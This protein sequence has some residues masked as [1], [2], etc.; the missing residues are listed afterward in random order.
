MTDRY[1]VIGNPI[2]HSKSPRIHAA[3]AAQ[4]G[5]A[6]EYGRILGDPGGF[7]GQV[8]GFFSRGGRGLNVTVP[9]KE[10]AWHLADEHAPRA[11]LAGAANTLILLPNG[12]IRGDN[13]D[14]VGLVR[15]LTGNQGLV[16]AGLRVLLLGAGGAARGVVGPLL[17]A[18]PAALVIANRTPAKAIA[19]AARLAGQ[20]P[21]RGCG[22]ESLS[23]TGFDLI[24]NATAA[25]LGGEVPAIPDDCLA[26][27]GVTY[28][29]M[30]ADRPTAFVEWGRA[31]GPSMASACCWSRQRN[32]SFCGAACAR[33]PDR[34]GPC[35]GR[36]RRARISNCPAARR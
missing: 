22:L 33:T 29:L 24:I 19:L 28:D 7:A 2:E 35:C 5:Q 23:G 10:E 18:G 1:A 16:L 13:T 17:Q 6:M 34:C 9:F 20:G 31:H 30:Y 27:P 25:G 21:V 14:G 15:D 26:P 3:F 11:T 12:C 4:T 8:R 32:P 36:P